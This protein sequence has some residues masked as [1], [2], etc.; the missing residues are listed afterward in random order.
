LDLQIPISSPKPETPEKDFSII[1]A[2]RGNTL[3]LWATI[4]SCEVE[5]AGSDF[6]YEYIVVT[7]G[8]ESKYDE[9]DLLPRAGSWEITTTTRS[10]YH[11][12]AQ[13]S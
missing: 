12:P 6:D 5:L 4:H 11:R 8:E 1:I 10:R 13:D 2:H 3:G 9:L 7:N